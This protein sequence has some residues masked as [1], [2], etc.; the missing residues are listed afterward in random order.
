MDNCSPL[1]GV[2]GIEPPTAPYQRDMLPLH[3]TPSLR[4]YAPHL[5]GVNGVL[6]VFSHA[7]I[8]HTPTALLL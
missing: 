2:G 8:E 3:Y 7:V 4:Y 1:V 6:G 5:I